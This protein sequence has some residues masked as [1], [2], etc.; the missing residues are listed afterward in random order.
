MATKCTVMHLP[1]NLGQKVAE[2]SA[3][4]VVP[5]VWNPNFAHAVYYS[6]SLDETRLQPQDVCKIDLKR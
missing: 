6:A 3:S 5:W 2:L 1:A 4:N